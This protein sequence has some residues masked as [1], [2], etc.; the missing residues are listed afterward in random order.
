MTHAGSF[1]RRC[2]HKRS[3]ITTARPCRRADTAAEAISSHPQNGGSVLELLNP[4]CRRTP[5]D[6]A[7]ARLKQLCPLLPSPLKGRFAF[8][9]V[10]IFVHILLPSA[11]PL[12]TIPFLVPDMPSDRCFVDASRCH[13]VALRPKMPVSKT[14]LLV[15]ML[16]KHPERILPLQIARKA[17]Y[18][19]LGY[20][21]ADAHDPAAYVL[22]VSRSPVPA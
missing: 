21:T 8:I 15:C 13:I 2:R 18:R 14:V 7:F 1:R 11:R 9:R 3:T 17:R 20:A 4:C 16:I 6:A 19:R 10:C 22:P 5:K 12:H